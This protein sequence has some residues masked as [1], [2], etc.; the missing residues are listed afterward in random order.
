MESCR[1][2]LKDNLILEGVPQP[3][4]CITLHPGFRPICLEKWALRNLTRKYKTRDQRRYKQTGS[5]QTY[6]SCFNF[7]F[8]ISNSIQTISFF[9]LRFLRSVA[10]R[11]CIFMIHGYLV[12]K[13]ELYQHVRVTQSDQ[14]LMTKRNNLRVLTM[15]RLSISN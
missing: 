2:V 9:L 11:E 10:Y 3:P 14:H 13:E 1:K 4:C 12:M 8:F 7:Q 15:N 6:A 5:E